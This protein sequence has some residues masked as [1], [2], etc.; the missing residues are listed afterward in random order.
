MSSEGAFN[1]LLG[2]AVLSVTL[3]YLELLGLQRGEDLK[4]FSF[5]CSPWEGFWPLWI[6]TAN[7]VSL[8]EFP[9]IPL[10]APDSC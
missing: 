2:I 3:N 5:L 1:L 6:F 10:Y 4:N 9:S 7:Q 8:E